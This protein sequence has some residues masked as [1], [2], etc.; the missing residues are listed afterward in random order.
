M[1]THKNDDSVVA[2][3]QTVQGADDPAGLGVHE[4]GRGVIR[5]HRLAAQG[6]IHRLLLPAEGEG[7]TGNGGAIT[8]RRCRRK[9]DLIRRVPV[10]VL[11]WRDIRRVRT[12]KSHGQEEWAIL[13]PF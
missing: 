9:L 5:G 8:L 2:Q 3:L 11:L 13:V 6:I 1:I 12:E 4:A 10:K 7:G